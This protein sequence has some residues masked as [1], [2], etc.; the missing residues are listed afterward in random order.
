MELPAPMV[1]D[2][3]S[4]TGHALIR[5]FIILSRT[6]LFYSGLVA[7]LCPRFCSHLDWGQGCLAAANLYL[8]C[9]VQWFIGVRCD[10][11]LWDYCTFRVEAENDAQTAG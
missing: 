11:D 3:L 2:I 7:E 4:G 8:Q 9:T 5:R 6:A 1:N 10:H